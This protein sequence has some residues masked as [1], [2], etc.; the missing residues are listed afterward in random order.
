M[1]DSIICC[2]ILY[3]MLHY[4]FLGPLCRG[5]G[6]NYVEDSCYWISSYNTSYDEALEN[7]HQ[8]VTVKRFTK[9]RAQVGIPKE[10]EQENIASLLQSHDGV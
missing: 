1:P 8:M 4:D 10:A 6:W 7:C 9:H 3:C 5:D 2:T